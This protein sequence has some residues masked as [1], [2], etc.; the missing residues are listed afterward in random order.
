VAHRVSVPPYSYCLADNAIILEN[1]LFSFFYFFQT[2]VSHLNYNDDEV[3]ITW[4]MPFSVALYLAYG[5]DNICVL[6]Y[7]LGH[8]FNVVAV[9]TSCR[10]QGNS[11]YLHHTPLL[12][13]K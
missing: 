8:L 3:F 6:L 7:F 10:P 12:S 13:D 5:T 4:G 2:L 11:F 9:A 1:S